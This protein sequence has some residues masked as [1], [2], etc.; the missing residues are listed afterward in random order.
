ML[1]IYPVAPTD[2]RCAP[3]ALLAETEAENPA[4]GHV[5]RTAVA[6]A[7]R[8]MK[9]HKKRIKDPQIAGDIKR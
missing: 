5:G 9:E 8:E 3:S 4:L 1:T 2:H 6:I 7:K